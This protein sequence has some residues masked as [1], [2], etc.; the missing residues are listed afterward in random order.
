MKRQLILLA[1]CFLVCFATGCSSLP[2]KDRIDPDAEWTMVIESLDGDRADVTIRNSDGTATPVRKGNTLRYEGVG[3]KAIDLTIT[4]S[5]SK[6]VPGALEIAS[7]VTNREEGW[8][9]LSLET[10]TVKGLPT[11]EGDAF[12]M[13]TGTGWR[14]PLKA[15][16]EAPGKGAKA[17]SPWKWN[18]AERI[19][20][21]GQDYPS[22][23][24]SMQWAALQGETGGWY[25]A[26]QDTSFSWKNMTAVYRPETGE[27]AFRFCHHMTCFPGETVQVPSDLVY[28][29]EG[30]WHKAADLYRTWFLQHREI[31]EKP[32][33][34]RRNTGWLLAI[35]KQQNDEVIFPYS[36]LGGLLSDVAEERGIDVLGVFGRGIGGHD[37][38]YP[39]YS[40]DPKL[41]GD[42]AFRDGIAK[43]HERGRKV[44]V[45]TNGQLLDQEGTQFWPDTG[46]F[47]T[48]VRKD[49]TLDYQ[50][51]HKYA[52]APAR[53]HGM[54]CQRSDIWRD[55]MLRLARQAKDLG[56]DGLLYDQ[57]ATRRPMLCYSPD[58]GHTVPAIVYENDRNDNMDYVRREMAKIDPDFIVMT[59]GLVDAEMNVI[60]MFHGC[61]QAA[62]IPLETAFLKRFTDEASQQYYP[63]LFRY[64]F[65]ELVTTIR[66]PNPAH[67]RFSVNYGVAFG[68]RSELELRY[69]AD[70]AYVEEG[71]IPV[72]AD[73]GNVLSPPNLV[74]VEEAGD[75]DE[76]K[77]YTGKVLTF[78]KEHGDL[79]MEGRFLGGKG[80]QL[81]CASPF[82][83]ANAFAS[84]D[85]G[86]LG[87]LVWNVSG[88]APA[89]F[90]V[91]P[92]KGWELLETAAPEG[93]AVEGPLPA[94]SLRLLIYGR[95]G[96]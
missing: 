14:L 61:S 33:W 87:V 11:A 26:S 18:K 94:R 6:D 8:V 46:R 85:G 22:L 55:I 86:K 38:F 57:L 41:G 27:A 24:C 76:A 1:G 15:V 20:S 79:L 58:H 3:G 65:P 52:D 54:A 74:Y 53:I 70:R 84:A 28:R 95:G 77:A 56:A 62:G 35:M 32:E 71:K 19:Y 93:E 37:R 31:L 29:Y 73:Y 51:W 21:Y 69:A 68:F 47:I 49:G 44:I 80:V 63:E 12:F 75:P 30:S 96:R 72:K 5:A 4:Y 36:D 25:F 48:V 23:R 59:E 7:T 88:E 13:P 40:S 17:P 92:E 42:Q 10:P 9:V 39:D 66:H 50:K 89:T 64:T 34:V 16:A 43:A 67:S 91:T 2:L 90:T 45:Y 81:D 60:G 78:Q 82:V 83:L